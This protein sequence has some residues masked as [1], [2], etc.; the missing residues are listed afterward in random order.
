MKKICVLCML[1]LVMLTTSVFAASNINTDRWFWAVSNDKET[2]Y[3]DK[4]DITYNPETDTCKTWVLRD[5]PGLKVIAICNVEI[6]YSK[7]VMYVYDYI[8]YEYGNTTPI[9]NG[10]SNKEE[11]IFPDSML[12]VLKNK[13]LTLINR[14]EELAEYKKQQEDEA[15]QAEQERKDEEKE[16][17]NKEI[18]NTAIGIIGGLF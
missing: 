9:G 14:D 6:S 18:A 1:M 2:W 10:V 12:E 5:I 7:N 4:T 8:M 15:K 11:K 17:R 13:S 16:Q 3:I